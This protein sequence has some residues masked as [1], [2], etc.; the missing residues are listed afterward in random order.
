[1]LLA[2]M[3]DEGPRAL[4]MLYALAGLVA[5]TLVRAGL[6]CSAL[7]AIVVCAVLPTLE[8]SSASAPSLSA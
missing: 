5:V 4:S 1:M 6:I 2:V 3:R 8:T 7:L